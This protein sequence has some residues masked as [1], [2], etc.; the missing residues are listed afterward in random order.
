MEEVKTTSVMKKVKSV[1][2]VD[3]SLIVSVIALILAF[4]AGIIWFIIG[5]STIYQISTI[6][7]SLEPQ[8]ADVVNSIAASIT[9]MGALY[10]IIVW[11]ILTFIGTFIITAIAILLYNYLAPRIGYIKLELE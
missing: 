7:I 1:P 11:P 5:W 10:L 3:V 9:G 2:V 6:I 4:I 8:T